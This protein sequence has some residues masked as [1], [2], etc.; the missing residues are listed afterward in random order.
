M[1]LGYFCQK[2]QASDH[3]ISD[4]N[5]LDL[6]GTSVSMADNYAVVGAQGDDANNLFLSNANAGQKNGNGAVYVYEKNNKN[7]WNYIQKIVR[8]SSGNNDNFGYSISI[9]TTLSSIFLVIGCSMMGLGG[10]SQSGGRPVPTSNAG[11]VYVYKLNKIQG[12]SWEFGLVQH[13]PIT[14]PTNLSNVYWQFGKSVHISYNYFIVGV[15]Y[16]SNT[17]FYRDRSS[18]CL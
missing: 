13:V 8:P 3:N 7:K 10:S 18:I 12:G 4:A 9:S 14:H 17:L 1:I 16:E 15:Q 11:G 6:F 2:L 5:Y